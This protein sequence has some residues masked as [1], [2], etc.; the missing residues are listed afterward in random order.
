MIITAMYLFGIIQ[1]A[2]GFSWEY[3]LLGFVMDKVLVSTLFENVAKE[4]RIDLKKSTDDSA[5]PSHAVNDGEDD[6][7]NNNSDNTTPN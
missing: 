1:S 3:G 4:I 7:V 6:Q 2:W 5:T